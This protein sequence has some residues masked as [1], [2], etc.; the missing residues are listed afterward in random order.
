MNFE[1]CPDKFW[2]FILIFNYHPTHFGYGRTFDDPCQSCM[3]INVK[4]T[5]NPS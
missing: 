5:T 3:H 1:N 4:I 2:G